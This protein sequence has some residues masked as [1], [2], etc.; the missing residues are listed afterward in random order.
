LR[1]YFPGESGRE[2]EAPRRSALPR[3][4][5]GPQPPVADADPAQPAA[6]ES[7]RRGRGGRIDWVVGIALGFL[8]GIAVVVV[9]VFFGSEETIDAPSVNGSSP[10][11]AKQAPPFTAP[12]GER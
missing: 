12:T 6:P 2:E 5:P 4:V 10:A 9:F 11:A 3:P 7:G 1:G 8:V